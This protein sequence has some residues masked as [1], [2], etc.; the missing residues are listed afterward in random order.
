VYAQ[1]DGIFACNRPI[2][3]ESCNYI[4]NSAFE[5]TDP[6]ISTNSAF[7]ANN[8]AGWYDTHGS[9]D[10]NRYILPFDPNVNFAS[11]GI[12]TNS[13]SWYSEGIA[14]KIPA[15]TQGK[16]YAFSFFI[17]SNVPTG[18]T[19]VENVKFNVAL[20]N[21][22][23]FE[24]PQ[25]AFPG[26]LPSPNQFIYCEDLGT[27]GNTGWRQIFVKFVATGNFDMIRIYPSQVPFVSSATASFVHFALPELVEVTDFTAG[28]PVYE[29]N[30]ELTITPG[31]CGV[32]N[33]Q[34]TWRDPNNN[35]VQQGPNQFLFLN[36]ANNPYGTYTLTMTVPGA[37]NTN[38]TCSDNNPVL[39]SSVDI[40]DN[41]RCTGQLSIGNA[42][43][44]YLSQFT[45]PW[46]TQNLSTC[47]INNLCNRDEL[48]EI[49]ATSNQTNGNVWEVFPNT[50]NGSLQ[51]FG[52][53]SGNSTNPVATTQNLDLQ[54]VLD[55]LGYGEVEIRLT[56]TILNISKS[57]IIRII[58]TSS[59]S[60]VCY[61]NNYPGYKK[62]VGFTQNP[63]TNYSWTFP[64]G[65]TVLPNPNVLEVSYDESQYSGTFPINATLVATSLHGCPTNTQPL[66]IYQAPIYCNAK[67]IEENNLLLKQE[68]VTNENKSK[69]LTISPN[70]A[71]GF[72]KINSFKIVKNATILNAQGVVLKQLTQAQLFQAI[73][74]SDLKPG[75]Y[76]IKVF[77]S[78]KEYEVK[79]II[80][81]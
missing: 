61:S 32:R 9:T 59:I 18:F 67:T 38:N 11:M 75:T 62:L 42:Q 34:Y 27:I 44:V 14:A 25:S 6:F 16:T 22:Q 46:Y 17:A 56:N 45:G 58:P 23:N 80:K 74:I 4:P 43:A 57:I 36:M 24:P 73:N 31:N 7:T 19:A 51:F 77:Y 49:S 69:H 54:I 20:I 81:Q 15:L 72:I 50:Y 8:V 39:V 41:C 53:W 71:N 28:V 37:S 65:M 2:V 70:P 76:F 35:I 5:L 66:T 30:C 60:N 26:T 10:I 12:S 68:M 48:I 40:V 55:P 21:C 78:S 33:A 29:N 47:T 63:Y 1:T 79:T 13:T 64:S 52:S 3:L